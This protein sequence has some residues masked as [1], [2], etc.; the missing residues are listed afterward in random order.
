LYALATRAWWSNPDA[1]IRRMIG[2][3]ASRLDVAPNDP[4]MLVLT[5]IA[6]PF[7]NAEVVLDRA[8]RR[9][10][11]R[12]SDPDALLTI[13]VAL[14][15]IG[16]LDDCARHFAAADAVLRA[17]GRLMLVAVTLTSSALT[18][19]LRGNFAASAASADE[20]DRL[21]IET[22][23][24]GASATARAITAAL[25]AIRGDGDR[26]LAIAAEVEQV[27][28]PLGPNSQLWLIAQVRATVALGEDRPADSFNYWRRTFNPTDPTYHPYLLQAGIMD[29]TEAGVACGRTD[30][31]RR[32]LA[33]YFA[34][35]GTTNSQ[36][37]NVQ[38][39]VAGPMLAA[40]EDAD[41]AYRAALESA[42]AH[43]PFVRARLLLAYGTWLRRMRRVSDS[44][45]PLRNA[46]DIFDALGA[47]FWADRAR[48][49]LRATGEASSQP[50]TEGLDQLTPQ[51]LQVI[52]LA[53]EGLTNKEIGERLYLSHRT[54][55][56]HL[57]RAFPKLGISSRTQI[58]GVLERSLPAGPT[59]SPTSAGQ[60]A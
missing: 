48:R 38:L 36:I 21:A 28:A 25:A 16:A 27:F 10:P 12:P 18:E 56:V 24:L 23:Q 44:R 31:V 9:A 37:L 58:R 2:D 29:F 42:H 30:E 13:G 43:W 60:Q 5:A 11:G 47:T 59:T 35:A 40:D 34:V 4:M 19:F 55:G 57:Y 20:C 7:G 32:T 26:A 50:T 41:A 33:P 45:A 51:E 39:T 3:A 22:G 6:D 53:A 54:V 15:V 46:R 8:L 52:E 14:S 49:T 1:E 17:Q